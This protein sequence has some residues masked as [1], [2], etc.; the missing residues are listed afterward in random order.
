M[1]QQARHQAAARMTWHHPCHQAMPG[2]LPRPLRALRER[3]ARQ[4]S[5]RGRGRQTWMMLTLLG[6]DL[7]NSLQSQL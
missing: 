6:Q 4:R 7:V 3:Q 1:A 2:H 5:R